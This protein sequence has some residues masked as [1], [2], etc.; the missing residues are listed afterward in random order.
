MK[1]YRIKMEDKAAFLNRMKKY[2]IPVDITKIKDNK[3]EGYFSIQFENPEDVKT[4]NILLN[5]APKINTLHESLK[6]IDI[7]R[8]IKIEKPQPPP[9]IKWDY[10]DMELK[11]GESEDGSLFVYGKISGMDKNNGNRYIARYEA[12]YRNNEID[13]DNEEIYGLELLNDFD[14]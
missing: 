10:T 1:I 7:L 2:N 6:L 13:Y 9:N 12:P 8:E 11:Q 5:K 14:F 3:L 4:I